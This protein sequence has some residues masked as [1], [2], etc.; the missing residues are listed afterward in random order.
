[1][2]EYSKLSKSELEDLGRKYGLELD[3]RFLKSKMV[4]QLEDHISS[5]S[6]DKLEELGREDG[7][8]LDKR[9]KKEKL[10]DQIAN[11]FKKPLTNREKWLAQATKEEIKRWEE[12]PNNHNPE[13]RKA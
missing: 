5:L 1:M 8:E 10:I 7:I 3:R 12:D 2:S 11:P 9:L 13:Q 4:K 6:K